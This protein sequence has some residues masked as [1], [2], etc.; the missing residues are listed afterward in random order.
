MMD[1]LLQLA[2]LLPTPGQIFVCILFGFLA[3]SY[4]LYG[5]RLNEIVTHPRNRFQSWLFAA[6]F[7]LVLLLF[8]IP[9]SLPSLPAWLAQPQEFVI[10]GY[11]F[12]TTTYGLLQTASL[13]LFFVS[14]IWYLRSCKG[15]SFA[16]DRYLQ[17]YRQLLQE[18]AFLEAKQ[19]EQPMPWYF[20]T[21]ADKNAYRLLKMSYERHSGR[22]QET[23]RTGAEIQPELLYPEA[24]K[25]YYIHLAAA[26]IGLGALTRAQQA[27]QSLESAPAITPPQNDAEYWNLKCAL[28]NA[29]GD[30]DEMEHCAR[31]GL[32]CAKETEHLEKCCLDNNL[33]RV[34]SLQNDPV[35][36]QQYLKW[37]KRELR[38][39]GE[40]PMDLANNIYGN[41]LLSLVRSDPEGP[42]IN[43]LREEYE[44]LVEGTGK[45]EN[46]I[47]YQ[48]V[49]VEMFRQCGI[50][51]HCQVIL[52]GYHRIMKELERRD[53][54]TIT[55][56]RAAIQV[57]TLRML[58]NGNFYVEKIYKQILHD[59]DAYK[60]LPSQ[61]VLELYKELYCLIE[62]MAPPYYRQFE[63]VYHSI[64]QYL[65]EKG[66]PAV[67]AILTGLSEYD[68]GGYLYWMQMKEFIL[69]VTYGT[70]F[71]SHA[72]PLYRAVVQRCHA[73]GRYL[74]ELRER[75]LWLDSLCSS[76]NWGPDQEKPPLL[77]Q[78]PELLE[79]ADALY[80]KYRV[81]PEAI[82]FSLLLSGIYLL[83]GD[84]ERSRQLLQDFLD[85]RVDIHIFA[86][87]LRMRYYHLLQEH[88]MP[89]KIDYADFQRVDSVAHA[90]MQMKDHRLANAVSE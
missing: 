72:E 14:C 62:Q 18:G 45:I 42:E 27:L 21:K 59:F 41:L 36:E 55:C 16:A 69:R 5:K 79:E 34:Y 56:E 31:T 86:A 65:Q 89:D 66:L 50:N 23:V 28:A 10:R 46:Y 54:D 76:E 33:G 61:N 67:E 11:K 26:Y 15:P 44:A 13:A 40:P 1:I 17:T 8:L 53:G 30:L 82:E 37:A 51:E 90:S 74:S 71:Y 12:Q 87:W 6:L 20:L 49:L 80:Q 78:N 4:L 39:I 24:Q 83:L 32:A 70:A 77:L 7:V 47:Q 58:V 38:Q 22:Y 2:S 19:L 75:M 68:M 9:R 63:A 57:S 48:N 88:G 29:D 84:Q 64:R 25:Q 52:S 3:Y 35:N 81:W 73:E 43:P 85:S 60:D